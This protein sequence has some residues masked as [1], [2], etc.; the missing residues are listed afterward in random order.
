MRPFGNLETPRW[1][2][3]AAGLSLVVIAC[4]SNGPSQSGTPNTVVP[5]LGSSQDGEGSDRGSNGTAGSDTAGDNTA[6]VSDSASEDEVGGSSTTQGSEGVGDMPLELAPGTEQG[7]ASGGGANDEETDEEANLVSAVTI[8]DYNPNFSEDFGADCQVAEP[9]D[10]NID[11][12]PDLFENLDG[13]RMSTVADWR[14]RRAEIKRVVEKYIHGEKPARPE[15]VTGTVGGGTISVHVEHE[16][17]SIDFSASYAV[18]AGNPAPAIIA[19][20]GSSLRGSILA[21]E[22]VG[23]INYN[24]SQLAAEGSRNGLFTQLYGNTGASSQVAWAWGV[25]RIIDVLVDERDAGRND[26]IDPTALGVT[27]CSRLGK[28]AFTVGAFDERIALGIPQESGTAGVSAFRIVNERDVGPN[29][30][31]SQ[32]LGSAWTEA[33]GWFGAIFDD[34]RGNVN[35]IPGDAHSLV[36][37]YVPRAMVVLDNSR[38]GELG[39]NAQHAATVAGAMVANALGA[40]A[41]IAYHGGNPG[42]PHNHCTF[43]DTQEAPLRR[44]IRAHLTKVDEAD[45]RIEPQPSGTADLVRWIPWEA[46]ELR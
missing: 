23:T 27:G 2:T 44:A 31:P 26:I 16:G 42:D 24:H 6:P 3:L 29:G 5:A 32:S 39:A 36:A 28:A 34:Y 15:T 19:I 35:V 10:V 8:A 30:Q 43:Y 21:E 1:T 37:M 13:T 7:S 12:L 4:G 40:T 38:I 14:C 46:P 18:P 33:Q 20:G 45:G 9:Q 22:G 17:N 41:T 25:S 11:T